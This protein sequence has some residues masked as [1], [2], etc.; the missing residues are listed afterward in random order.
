MTP[1]KLSACHAAP[2]VDV[3][4]LIDTLGSGG[5][6]RQLCEL[7]TLLHG[8]GLRVH[9]LAYHPNDFY[10]ASL[11]EAGIRCTI[12][13]RHLSRL[14][15][16]RFV[17]DALCDLRPITV[18][19]FLSGASMLAELT[20]ALHLASFRLIV[21]ERHVDRTIS[22]RLRMRHFLH[23]FA[24]IVVANSQTQTDFLNKRAPHLRA[25]TVCIRNSVDL[26]R[27]HPVARKFEERANRLIV[28]AS[29]QANKNPLALLDALALIHDSGQEP[30]HLDWY[31]SSQGQSTLA[32][33]REYARR[34][35]LAERVTFHEQTDLAHKLLPGCDALVL[36]S[37][38]EACPNVICEALA[39]GVPVIA[40]RVG[41]IPALVVDGE[42]GYLF[43]PHHPESIAAAIRRLMA[44]TPLERERMQQRNRK[45]AEQLFRRERLLKENLAVIQ[46]SARSMG[47]RPDVLLIGAVP[48][49]I[50]GVTMHVQRLRESLDTRGV[51]YAY[52]DHRAHGLREMLRK[53]ASHRLCHIHLSDPLAVLVLVLWA[54][55]VGC[56]SV[57]TMHGDF[58]RYT[59][60]R[61]LARRLGVRYANVPIVLNRESEQIALAINRRTRR[62]G[63]FIPPSS[64]EALEPMVEK[65]LEDARAGCSRLVMTNAFRYVVDARQR[66]VYGIFALIDWLDG[67]DCRL[68][69][70]DPSGTYQTAARKR[71]TPKQLAH[72]IFLSVPHSFVAALSF[73]DVFIRNTTTDGDSLSI[74]EALAAG[75]PVWA[76]SV[77]TR[78]LGTHVYTTLDEIDLNAPPG[79][80]YRREPV[81]DSLVAIYDELRAGEA[82][83]TQNN[84]R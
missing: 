3:L 42:N 33:A 73:A 54:R 39:C 56:A 10:T 77:V 1:I 12:S 80:A 27:F 18:Y 58:A 59:G 51:A 67:G 14:Q 30:I 83:F 62:L 49:P 5:A 9:V 43:D 84:S 26:D 19:A 60:M 78:P 37:F 16:L 41:D 8:I 11:R 7:A 36:P 35:G 20:R 68:V 45:R 40:S 24:D 32:I 2:R 47:A 70:C 21:S 81:A 29:Y 44:C 57:V 17:W 82:L 46:S 48:P 4:L 79:E 25:K 71:Y 74:H 38:S 28:I 66:E 69:V 76:T 55:V 23:R 50:G 72:V 13:P 31:G 53:I 63:A 75:K 64:S 6:Q 15:R 61:R 34:R 52:Y 22:L 65:R